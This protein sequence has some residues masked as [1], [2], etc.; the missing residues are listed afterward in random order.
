VTRAEIDAA[1]ALAEKAT[2]GPFLV[3]HD[4]EKDVTY[5][6]RE[7][8]DGKAVLSIPPRALPN[9]R[10]IEQRR[11]NAEFFAASRDLV[12]ALVAEV[13]RWRKRWAI[14]HHATCGQC[15]PEV[16]EGND[17]DT[18]HCA[19]ARAILAEPDMAGKPQEAR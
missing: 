13:L 7:R 19:E 18:L 14:E 6:V 1:L 2:K 12:P 15:N 8:G 11:M 10:T 16:D 9:Q 4:A 5:F 3:R 17:E